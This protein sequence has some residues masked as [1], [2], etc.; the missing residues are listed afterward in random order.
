MTVVPFGNSETDSKEY[1]TGDEYNANE[2]QWW[3][4]KQA[5]DSIKI[6]GLAPIHPT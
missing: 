2:W 6:I 5:L 4:L 1:N 3:V